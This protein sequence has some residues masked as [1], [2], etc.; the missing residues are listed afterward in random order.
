MTCAPL[1]YVCWHSCA[2]I[3]MQEKR[4]FSVADEDKTTI[5]YNANKFIWKINIRNSRFTILWLKVRKNL[6]LK[7]LWIKEYLLS[8]EEFLFGSFSEEQLLCRCNIH[9]PFNDNRAIPDA[10][11]TTSKRE[12]TAQQRQF[13]LDNRKSDTAEASWP[14]LIFCPWVWLRVTV[15]RGEEMQK[16]AEGRVQKEREDWIREQKT[17]KN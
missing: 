17:K 1:Q 6:K 12:N 16:K 3:N 11:N 8:S 5:S 2:L 9:I 13:S 4:L 7:A 14:S 15:K 10:V